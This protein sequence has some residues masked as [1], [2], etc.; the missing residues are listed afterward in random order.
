MRLLQIEENDSFSLVER[1]GSDVPPYAILSHTW[2]RDSDEV[3]LKDIVTG[4]GKEKKGFRKLAF[5]ATQAKSRGMQFIWVDTCCIDKTSSAELTEAI[6][7]MFRWYREAY[8]CYVYL[9]D[10]AMQDYAQDHTLLQKS[11]WFTRGWT[12]QEL[13]APKSVRFF[14][15]EGELLGDRTSLLHDIHKI[16]RIDPDALKGSPLSQFSIETRLSW[17]KGRQ[18]KREEDAA[19]SLLG[20]FDTHMPLIYGEGRRK[21][22]NRLQK[23]LK[24]SSMSETSLYSW[25]GTSDRSSTTASMELHDHR[26]PRNTTEDII[27]QRTVDAR[28]K[29]LQS[30]QFDREQERRNQIHDAHNGTYQW[31]L[32]PDTAHQPE[33]SLVTWL[34]SP[35][36]SRRIYWIHGKPGSGKSTI[37]RFLD[38]NIDITQHMLPW[39]EGK[40]ILTAR[41]FAWNPGSKLQKSSVGLLRALLLQLLSAQPALISGVIGQMNWAIAQGP[42]AH[43]FDWTYAELQRMLYTF[44]SSAQSS[45]TVLLLLDGLDELEDT[46]ETIEELI[47]FLAKLTELENVKICL[48]SRPWNIFRD[49]FGDYPQLTL[50]DLTHNDIYTYV[51]THLG[52]QPRF[53]HIIQYDRTNAQHLILGVTRRASGVFLWVRLVV[54]ELLKGLRDGDGIHT[55]Q[56]KLDQIPTDL[57]HYFTRLIDSVPPQHRQEACT[58]LQIA[59]Y[60]EEDFVTLHP[61]RLIDLS[62]IDEADLNP[63]YTDSLTPWSLDLAGW[64]VLQYR[65]DTTTRRVNSRCMGILE[66]HD[67]STGHEGYSLREIVEVEGDHIPNAYNLVVDF[68]HRTCRDFLL[69]EEM[70]QTLHQ[71]TKGPYDACLYLLQ[72]RIAQFM[73]LVESKDNH[74]Q[75]LAL[76]SNIVSSLARP[77]YKDTITCASLAAMIRPK[78]EKLVYSRENHGSGG[79]ISSSVNSWRQEHSSFLT[80]AIDFELSAYVRQNLTKEVV[81]TKT[82]RPILDYILRPRFYGMDRGMEIG[83]MRPNTEVLRNVLHFGANPNEHYQS[84]SVWAAYLCFLADLFSGEP[85]EVTHIEYTI[86]LDYMIRAGAHHQLPKAWLAAEGDYQL[87]VHELDNEQNPDALFSLRWPDAVRAKRRDSDLESEPVYDVADLLENFRSYLGAHVDRLKGL[88]RGLQRKSAQ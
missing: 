70:Q 58:L 12:L 24:D 32:R 11:R 63:V 82:G 76:A 56:T 38:R 86:A 57:N 23:E 79:Y 46:D 83:N 80:L 53:K 43:R 34:S 39:G 64:E 47:A 9:S 31:I 75:A 8:E 22:M 68:F 26:L 30:L 62:F 25:E 81:Q 66:C 7:S 87:Y 78:L 45:T 27:H 54:R 37:M 18:T 72:A 13:L 5:C 61:L 50:H 42:G 14:S 3:T 74:V 49:A 71:Y 69:S 16:T 40:V 59:L 15:V 36:E 51:S 48:S 73:A 6:N 10:I 17:A 33:D 65:L 2:G 28:Q 44:I 19:Y 41:Y 4:T 67:Y 60:E 20:I 35:S 29:I 21:A 55:L 88:I 84:S 77:S 52:R 85:L 1:L